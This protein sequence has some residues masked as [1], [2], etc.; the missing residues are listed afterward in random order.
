D[1][2]T[3]HVVSAQHGGKI[4]ARL[5]K[6]HSLRAQLIAIENY[7]GLGLVELQ[8]RVSEH[9]QAA[10]E[11]LAN[12]LIGKFGQA[13]RLGGGSDHE[14]H[15][16]VSASGQR[17]RN[18]RYD[19]YAGDLGKSGCGLKLK[20][21]GALLALVPGLSDHAAKASARRRDLES[22]GGFRKRLID[23]VNLRCEKLGLIQG[24]VRRRLHHAE[25]H[26]LVFLRRQLLLREKVK[27]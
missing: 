14:I 2:E 6:V 20:L 24:R 5:R 26:A 27:R 8:I 1:A 17:R 9:E 4:A 3:V 21:S 23:V 11:C 7:F 15:R 25:N 18:Q 13:L 16:K 12:Q 19:T 10:G 22:I